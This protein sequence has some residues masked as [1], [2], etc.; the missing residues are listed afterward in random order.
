[1][2]LKLGEDTL[3]ELVYPDR[4]EWIGQNDIAPFL[5]ELRLFKA[6]DLDLTTYV[7]RTL[8]PFQLHHLN[9]EGLYGILQYTKPAIFDIRLHNDLAVTITPP[10][11]EKL[12][13]SLEV[14]RVNHS[15]PLYL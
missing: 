10:V 2:P 12:Y 13:T 4:V 11:L 3:F 14:R 15:S 5:E 1:M 8:S 6:V 9:A 7:L